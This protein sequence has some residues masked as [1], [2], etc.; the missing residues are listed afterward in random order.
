MDIRKELIKNLFYLKEIGLQAIPISEAIKKLLQQEVPLE[1][2]SLFS[3][4]NKV[5]RCVKCTLHRVRK[6]VVWGEGPTEPNGLMII[7]EYPDRDEDF[8]GKP[9]IGEVGNL[10]ERMLAAINLKRESFFITHA[11]KCKTPGGRPPEQEEI[12]ACK[13]HLLKQIKHLKPKLILALGFT[14]PKVLL[15]G[16]NLTLVRG[17]I[18]KLKEINIFFTYHPSFVLKNPGI[19]RAVWEDLQKFRKFYEEMF[20]AS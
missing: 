7:S 20:L 8:Y 16:K 18:F 5:L 12:E 2:D 9:F 15:D 19:K 11:V 13:P 6:G 14:P 10:L 1:E 4:Q 3:L 17:K